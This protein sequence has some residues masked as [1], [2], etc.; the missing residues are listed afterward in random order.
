MEIILWRHA[1]AEDGGADLERAL[2]ERGIRQASRVGRWLRK[3]LRGDWR[4]IASPALRARQTAAGLAM[5]FE[6]VASIAPG[7][8]PEAVLN[9][10]QWPNG[11]GNV[12]IV[13]HQPT[14]GQVAARLLAG[15]QGD[16]LIRKGG[17]W[18]FC[19]EPA[20]G[21]GDEGSTRLKA[22]FGPD[23]VR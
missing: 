5:P 21:P 23:T 17:A 16:V 6:V 20:Q 10:S 3:R 8:E 12:V 14:L 15:R 13:G 11:P 2:T 22:V 1:E 19:A 7:A 4:V 9:A 18:W